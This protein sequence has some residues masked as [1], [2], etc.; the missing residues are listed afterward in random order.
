M[1]KE[2]FNGKYNWVVNSLNKTMTSLMALGVGAA[3][4]RGAKSRNVNAGNF[5]G[6]QSMKRMGKNMRKNFR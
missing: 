4:Y 6:G 5:F 3:I 2:S 1:T